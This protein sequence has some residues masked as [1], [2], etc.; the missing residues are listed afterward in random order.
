MLHVRMALWIMLSF[1]RGSK[2]RPAPLGQ[3]VWLD[4][5][6]LQLLYSLSRLFFSVYSLTSAPSIKIENGVFLYIV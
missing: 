6:Y 2:A 1:R 3:A 4:H 5:R